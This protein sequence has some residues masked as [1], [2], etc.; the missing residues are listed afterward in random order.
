MGS[1][2]RRLNNSDRL[3]V[4]RGESSVFGS[5][6]PEGLEELRSDQDENGVRGQLEIYPSVAQPRPCPL[7]FPHLHL[8][9]PAYPL[10]N[11]ARP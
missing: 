4:R 9:Q 10:G 2:D 3:G 11:W 1:R 7:T 6:G 5:H 8:D